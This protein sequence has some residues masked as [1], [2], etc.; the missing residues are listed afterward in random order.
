M[1]GGHEP[2]STKM[3]FFSPGLSDR[4]SERVALPDEHI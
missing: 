2:D 4:V 1:L 3:K